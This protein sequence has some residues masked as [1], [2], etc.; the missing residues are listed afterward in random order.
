MIASNSLSSVSSVGAGQCSAVASPKHRSKPG[1]SAVEVGV[2]APSRLCDR[3]WER[4]VVLLEMLAQAHRFVVGVAD[5]SIE[6]SC[7][8]I[9]APDL[10]IYLRAAEIAKSPLGLVHEQASETLT[11]MIGVN[12]LAVRPDQASE[13][14]TR[15][16]GADR[17]VVD[18]S[19]VALVANHDGPD[20]LV[21][22]FDHEKVVRVSG[23][24][25]V[26]IPV[27]VVP[28]SREPADRPERHERLA[29][30]RPV[31]PKHRIPRNCL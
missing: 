9:R 26:D 14:L 8:L 16:I 31:R 3:S 22:L 23:Q 30:A 5:L 27:G 1:T 4:D 13:T 15:M 25:A 12:S 21:A 2:G 18:P 7:G 28:R 11:P 6:L 10:E 19:A 20:Q 29:V 17:E 24:L